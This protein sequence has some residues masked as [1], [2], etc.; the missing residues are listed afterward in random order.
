MVDILFRLEM[1]SFAMNVEAEK[2]TSAQKSSL[3]D[4]LPSD[5]R[6][7]FRALSLSLESNFSSSSVDGVGD[8]KSASTSG[9]S[10]DGQKNRKSS[11]LIDDGDLSRPNFFQSFESALHEVAQALTLPL[12]PL[13]K[14]REK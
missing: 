10:S 4:R 3:L 5:R 13:D 11:K 7:L 9:S 8:K 12:R 6:S 1:N 2:I 14:K